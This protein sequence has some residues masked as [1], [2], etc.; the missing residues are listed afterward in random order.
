[1]LANWMG[2]GEHATSCGFNVYFPNCWGWAYFLCLLCF[3]FPFYKLPVQ[4]SSNSGRGVFYS[5]WFIG[6]LYRRWTILSYQ[7]PPSPLVRNCLIFYGVSHQ[8]EV[9][10]T[11]LIWSDW[12]L[13]PLLLG[14][15]MFCLKALPLVRY[16]KGILFYFLSEVRES[17]FSYRSLIH[18]G[19]ERERESV[20]VCVCAH[21][22]LLGRD[23]ILSFSS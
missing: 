4:S 19:R 14:L 17:W 2:G 12:S 10:K 8:T 22:F 15:L 9:N 7:A 6:A 23:L 3:R 1:M 16:C 5:H 20:C 13:F 18:F 21:M 11:I